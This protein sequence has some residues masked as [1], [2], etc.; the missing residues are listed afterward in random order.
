[1]L[2][3]IWFYFFVFAVV[4]SKIYVLNAYAE[5]METAE[6]SENEMHNIT[7]TGDAYAVLSDKGVLT[8]FR[9]EN[10]YSDKTDGVFD[11]IYGNT[12]EGIVY[13]GIES[14]D[15]GNDSEPYK[16]IPWFERAAE[17]RMIKTMDDQPVAPVSMSFWF[18]NCRNLAEVDLSGFSAGNVTDM[19]QM[20][21]GCSN[22]ASLDLSVLDTSHVE[23]MR[24]M[25]CDCSS[26]RELN[27]NGLNTANV[28]DMRSL[29]EGCSSLESI[30]LSSFDTSKVENMSNMF[31]DCKNLKSLDVSGFDTASVTNM[32]TMFGGCINLVSLDLSNFD[33][34]K[35]TNMS[36]MFSDMT[37]KYLDISS[38]DLSHVRNTDGAVGSTDGAFFM[39]DYLRSIKLGDRCKTEYNWFYLPKGTWVNAELGISRTS[40]ELHDQYSANASEWAGEWNRLS[41]AYAV[42]NDEN[43][44][45]FF[46]NCANYE[47]DSKGTFI[48]FE[49]NQYSGTLF[50]DFENLKPEDITDMPWNKA[51]EQIVSIK[52]AASQHIKPSSMKY[53]F[54]GCKN[55]KKVDLSGFDTSETTDMNGLFAECSG[56]EELDLSTFETGSVIDM[57][58]MFFECRSLKT[59]NIDGFDTS[60]VTN[61]ECMF[62]GCTKLTDINLKSFDTSNVTDMNNMFGECA[63]LSSLDVSGF[64]TENVKCMIGIF[65]GCEKLQNLDLSTFNTGNVTE[66]GFMFQ[67]CINLKSLD[68]SSFDTSNVYSMPYMFE[69]CTSLLSLDL[70]SFDTG[71]VTV[72]ENM[73]INCSS[74]QS[75]KL[76]T[77]F[78]HWTD[79]AYLPFGKW[80]NQQLDLIYSEQELYKLYPQNADLWAGEWKKFIP[81]SDVKLSS[82]EINLLFGTTATLTASITPENATNKDVTWTSSDKNIAT[83]DNSGFVKTVT[84]GTAV[85]TAKSVDGD[86][87]AHCTVRVYENDHIF[88]TPAYLWTDDNSSVT[89]SVICERCKE[90]ITETVKTSYSVLK[91][92]TCEES[93]SAVY[94]ANFKTTPFT[95]QS[96]TVYFDALGHKYSDYQII[97]GEDFESAVFRFVCEHDHTHVVNVDAAVK[98]SDKVPTCDT[99]GFKKAEAMA[100][101]EGK[102]YKEIV[103]N[104]IPALGHQYTLSTWEWADDY[105]AAKA[106]F[107]CK[108]DE[109]HTIKIDAAINVEETDDE[110]KYIASVV[111]DGIVYSYIK[112]VSKSILPQSVELSSKENTIAVGKRLQLSSTVLP[113]NA[114][115]KSVTWSSS[116]ESVADVDQNGMITGKKV[117][118]VIITA[119]TINGLTASCNIRVLFKDVAESNKYY[120]NPVYWASDLAITKGY[121]DGTFKPQDG[122]TRAQMVTF[123]WRLAGQPEPSANAKRFP[124]VP[125][126]QYY[127]K[128]VRWAAEK[129]ITKGYADGTFKPDEV[130]LREHAV[131]FLYRFAGQPAIKN[132]KNPFNDIKTSDYYYKATLWASENKIANGYSTG[133]YAGGFGPKLTCLREHIVTFLYRYAK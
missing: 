20:F 15:A 32:A 3:K 44:L 119:T 110:R 70:S 22:L 132:I 57:G 8:F 27:V 100:L 33:T 23:D 31:F 129:G 58:G 66:M 88:N 114:N 42:L 55:L 85:I 7:V 54:W 93:G 124:D 90:V 28:S 89:G 79:D 56:I 91:E 11:D 77:K 107:I 43:E 97:W 87:E 35:V 4:F 67:G 72:M 52:T 29:F 49:G 99:E 108:R 131:T 82:D 98:T 102:N 46:R 133:K 1:M 62:C 16:N 96:K 104:I 101:F 37:L 17:I 115:N 116:Y 123:L 41:N 94:V 40:V 18:Y 117:G 60:H 103:T 51:A 48:D 78:V 80:F 38:F 84:A 14:L 74:L 73:F 69:F 130:C 71:N 81:V 86:Y 122:C 121:V 47:N 30:D 95:D 24:F 13:A 59:L 125:S 83:V 10:S 2:K 26:L 118:K 6:L 45:I 19:K 12:Y 126:N 36:Y 39:N 75:I 120:F 127:Y 128:A 5:D 105:S 25:L 111:L 76:G 9:S 63:S 112:T 68:L 34:S 65:Y 64:E 61:M 50:T 21:R 109:T 106:V 92:P 113:A 53:W